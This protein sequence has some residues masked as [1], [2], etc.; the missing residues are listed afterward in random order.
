MTVAQ[1]DKWLNVCLVGMRREW[2]HKKMIPP[3]TSMQRSAAICASPPRGPDWQV[4]PYVMFSLSSPQ[5]DL[6]ILI[7]VAVPVMRKCWRV[8]AY[9]WM[10]SNM[11]GFILLWATRASWRIFKALNFEWKVVPVAIERCLF[12]LVVS[13]ASVSTMVSLS[14][15]TEDVMVE[16]REGEGDDSS[17][18]ALSSSLKYSLKVF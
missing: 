18:F 14:V 3:R 17:Q 11:A 13:K 9:C 10:N 15:E 5:T 12:V 8:V 6:H 4:R 7:V 2:I 16:E 1:S